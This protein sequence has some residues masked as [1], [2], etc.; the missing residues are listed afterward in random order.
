MIQKEE[1]A[2]KTTFNCSTT[3][4]G[5]Y[6]DVQWVGSDIEEEIKDDSEKLG[7]LEENNVDDL[8]RRVAFLE[9]EMLLNSRGT[10]F[11]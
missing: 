1:N 9:R 10:F 4:T 3:C 2:S 5:I 8:Q 6:A 11:A 7:D